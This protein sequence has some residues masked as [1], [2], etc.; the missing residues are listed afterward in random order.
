MHDAEIRHRAFLLERNLGLSHAS[1]ALTAVNGAIRLRL[2]WNLCLTATG[3]ADSCKILTGPTSSI[4]T[5]IAA[6][7]AALRFILEASLCVKLLLTC[8]KNELLTAFLTY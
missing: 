4:L 3:S 6:V 2:K 7:L 8:S 1:K 5:C